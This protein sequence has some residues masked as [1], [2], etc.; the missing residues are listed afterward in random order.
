MEPSG[1]LSSAAFCLQFAVLSRLKLLQKQLV[2]AGHKKVAQYARINAVARTFLIS[3][4]RGELCS[5]VMALNISDD[6]EY[7]HKRAEEARTIAEQ[8][9]DTHM[10]AVMIGIAESYKKIAKWV[11]ERVNGEPR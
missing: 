7:C 2:A 9:R 10:K 5:D 4:E 8:M 3:T 1:L 11:E 6:P